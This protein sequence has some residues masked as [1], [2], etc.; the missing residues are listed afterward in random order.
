MKVYLFSDILRKKEET[1]NIER[2]FEA[3]CDIYRN[4]KM[5]FG[6][7]LEKK[8]LSKYKVSLPIFECCII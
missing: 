3:F 8:R 5:T 7:L 2:V 1:I 6:N 4:W